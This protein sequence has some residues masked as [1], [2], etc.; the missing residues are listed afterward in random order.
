MKTIYDF[1]PT[2]KEARLIGH[3]EKEKYLKIIKEPGNI[4]HLCHLFFR[5][6]D[7]ENFDKFFAMLNTDKQ[8]EF[9]HTISDT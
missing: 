8:S 9:I 2:E 4:I 5:R 1:N 7:K 3:F 6:K